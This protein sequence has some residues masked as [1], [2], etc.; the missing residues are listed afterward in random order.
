MSDKPKT[1]P[2]EPKPFQPTKPSENPGTPIQKGP[3]PIK[4]V[5]PSQSPGT[6]I[7][8]NEPRINRIIKE[9]N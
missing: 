2:Q 9:N 8:F 7:P 4:P 1:Q 6:R 5:Q 3:L